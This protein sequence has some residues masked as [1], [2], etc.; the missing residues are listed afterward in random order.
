MN[1]I[2]L[3]TNKEKYDSVGKM[4]DPTQI[5]NV[6]DTLLRAMYEPNPF[7]FYINQNT[8]EAKIN[9]SGCLCVTKVKGAH[10]M[11]FK[12]D[13]ITRLAVTHCAKR[14]IEVLG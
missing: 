12:L 9:T 13:K 4:I 10:Q 3:L 5:T 8:I 6:T 14:I 11:K 1:P 2:N 7:Y